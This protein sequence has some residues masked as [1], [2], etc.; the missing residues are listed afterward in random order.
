V[1]LETDAKLGIQ[2]SISKCKIELAWS[3]MLDFE[4]EQNPF[5]AKKESI[6]DWK[7]LA[8]TDIDESKGILSKAD[9]L[10]ALGLKPK[11]AIHVACA[12]EGGCDY[13]I[14]TDRKIL[15][16]AAQGI[17]VEGMRIVSPTRFIEEQK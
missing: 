1:K 6:A 15:N 13:F 11:D 3:Y 7:D 17:G 8:R 12:L 14:T 9:T 2:D 5:P 16:K 10:Q 4:N